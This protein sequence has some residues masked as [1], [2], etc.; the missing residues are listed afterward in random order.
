MKK[1]WLSAV[2]AT[3]VC[4]SALPAPAATDPILVIKG[5]ATQGTFK[6]D[7]SHKPNGSG[8]VVFPETHS[9]LVLVEGLTFAKG[10]CG[11]L[12]VTVFMNDSTQH[13][14]KMTDNADGSC[15][16]QVSVKPAGNTPPFGIKSFT[17]SSAGG[18]FKPRNI[19]DFT[20]ADWNPPTISPQFVYRQITWTYQQGNKTGQDAWDAK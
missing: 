19:T 14:T 15:S 8:H 20:A 3:F 6:G 7:A 12:M 16:Y 1:Y 17:L 13:S 9:N 11:D 18:K 4:A 10:G 5:G 2:V